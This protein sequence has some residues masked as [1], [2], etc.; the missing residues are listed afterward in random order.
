MQYL[1]DTNIC[2]YVTKQRPASV[3]ERFRQL[4]FRDLAVST[5]TVYE[6][7]YGAAK[8]RKSTEA[9]AAMRDFLAPPGDAAVR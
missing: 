8:S 1:L 9:L 2:I 4:S 5:I 7:A 3:I 6:L